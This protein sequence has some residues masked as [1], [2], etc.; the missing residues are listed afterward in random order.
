M[1]VNIM[2]PNCCLRHNVRV[3]ITEDG[4]FETT[5]ISCKLCGATIK[6]TDRPKYRKKDLTSADTCHYCHKD[7]RK[8]HEIHAVEGMLFC[9]KEHAITYYRDQI[10][11]DAVKSAIAIYNDFAEVVTAEDIGIGE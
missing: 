7:L 11:R 2:C 10:I 8:V 3:K 1:I 4:G 5:Y 9:S 6:V